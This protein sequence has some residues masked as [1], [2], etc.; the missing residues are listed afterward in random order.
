MATISD[1]A[2]THNQAIGGHGNTGSGP[3]ALV[4]TSLGGGIVSSYG[5]VELGPD[6]LTVSNSTLSQNNATGGDNNSGNASVAGLFGAGVGG[7]IANYLGSAAS[8]SGSELDL[9]QASGGHG[10]TA[11][12]GGAAFAGLGAG[13]GIFNYLGNYN[14]S[15]YGPLNAS[16]VTVSGC[17]I[18]SNQAQGGGGGNGEGGGLANLLSATA[19]L[20]G[21]FL[22]QNQANSGSGAG[23]GGGAYND[24][25]SSLALSY[26][27]VTLNQAN[28]SP[29][30]AAASTRSGRLPT[31]LPSSPAT[32]PPPAAITSDLD[33]CWQDG[34]IR[35]EFR[36]V[37]FA[38]TFQG[39]NT[40]GRLDGQARLPLGSSRSHPRGRRPPAAGM[41]PMGSW[42]VLRS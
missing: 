27:V 35:K 39:S 2:F 30:S 6:S 37:V 32:M 29:G 9:N 41:R 3:V 28:G 5:G 10:N 14:S 20:T 12:G 15:G 25:S 22:I 13:G 33:R 34:G 11:G 38:L 7:G 17:L 1:T 4:G 19:T 40:Y 24:A 21:S 8:V 16:V 31:P 23:L 42:P 18:Q 36:L 26:C